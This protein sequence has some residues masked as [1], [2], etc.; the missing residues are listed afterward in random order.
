[1]M[2]FNRNNSKKEA[3]NSFELEASKISGL[4]EIPECDLS[5]LATRLHFTLR[6]DD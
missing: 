5:D 2:L 4:S 1:M 3:P 6:C